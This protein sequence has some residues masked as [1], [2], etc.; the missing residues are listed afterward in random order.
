[1]V[2]HALFGK[3]YWRRAGAP[4]DTLDSRIEPILVAAP[5]CPGNMPVTISFLEHPTMLINGAAAK[6][7]PAGI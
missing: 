1:M 2:P 5:R 4:L 6:K 3:H 7:D